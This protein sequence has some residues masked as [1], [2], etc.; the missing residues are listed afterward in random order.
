MDDK[1]IENRAAKRLDRL[2]SRG[3]K[4]KKKTRQEQ[5]EDELRKSGMSEQDIE[6]LRGKKKE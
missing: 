3:K 6:R 5:I 1:Q 4:E 2:F